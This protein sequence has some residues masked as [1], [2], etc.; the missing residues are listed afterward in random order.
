MLTKHAEMRLRHRG[1]HKIDAELVVSLGLPENAPGGATKYRLS[2]KMVRELIRS[3]NRMRNGAIAI[4]G[5][6]GQI[7]TVYKEYSS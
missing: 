1:F 6:A 4:M 2:G 5:E 7:Q 3:L